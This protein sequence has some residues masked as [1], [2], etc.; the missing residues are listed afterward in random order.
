MSPLAR[1]ALAAHDAFDVAPLSTD[2]FAAEQVPAIA[3]ALDIYLALPQATR[4]AIYQCLQTMP[5]N[6]HSHA[7]WA[8]AA[9]F[10]NALHKASNQKGGR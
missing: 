7:V 6:L 2:H 3:K 9:E 5:V 1:Y 10:G 4:E 8:G